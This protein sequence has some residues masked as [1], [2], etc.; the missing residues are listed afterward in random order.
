MNIYIVPT[1]DLTGS[2]KNQKKIKKKSKKNP[3]KTKK[4]LTF[5]FQYN[6]FYFKHYSSLIIVHTIVPLIYTLENQRKPN[7]N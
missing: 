4:K 2:K 3:K 7:K 5:E 1:V 6:S